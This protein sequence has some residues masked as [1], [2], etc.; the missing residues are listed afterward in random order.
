MKLYSLIVFVLLLGAG[1][2]FG[3]MVGFTRRALSLIR[4]GRTAAAISTPRYMAV[5]TEQERAAIQERVRRAGRLLEAESRAL[6][7]LKDWLSPT[8]LAQFKKENTFDVTGSYTGYCYRI[9]NRTS[10]NVARIEAD[11]SVT[12][13]ICFLPEGIL[14]R[15]DIMLAQK[16]ALET[17]ERD[18]LAV[19]NW[20]LC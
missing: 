16:I 13:T 19:A 4:G 11:G 17:G 8:Q 6:I 18:V 2:V 12:S 1:A 7:L 5:G 14:A 20:G 9:S 3:A 10:F 15:G